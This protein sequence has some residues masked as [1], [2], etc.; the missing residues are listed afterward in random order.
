MNRDTQTEI[1]R[2]SRKWE[3]SRGKVGAD[4]SRPEKSEILTTLT[5]QGLLRVGRTSSSTL[6]RLL[7]SPCDLHRPRGDVRATVGVD[8]RQLAAE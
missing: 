5:T 6:W 8:A 3:M 7:T 4:R 2:R 1:L